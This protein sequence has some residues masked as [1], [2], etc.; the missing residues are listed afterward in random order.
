MQ[1]GLRR[2]VVAAR[3]ADP[4]VGVIRRAQK[5]GRA[6]EQRSDRP[7]LIVQRGDEQV[8]Q[9]GEK[10][11]VLVGHGGINTCA[12][13]VKTGQCLGAYFIGVEQR[14]CHQRYLAVGSGSAGMAKKPGRAA[15]RATQRRIAG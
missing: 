8:G 13:A 14:L 11:A 6:A 4:Q 2:I 9:R 3:R 12:H 15:M 1:C 5:T 7:A 10:L